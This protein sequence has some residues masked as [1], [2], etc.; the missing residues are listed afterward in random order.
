MRFFFKAPIFASMMYLAVIIVLAVAWCKL[1]AA[2]FL[3]L[4]I[5]GFVWG[6]AL[7]QLY[8]IFSHMWA[9]ALM[10]EY[11]MWCV[12]EMDAKIYNLPIVM[13]YA[14]YHHH[15][16][17]DDNWMHDTMSYHD[18]RGAIATAYAHWNSFSLLTSDYLISG[19]LMKI[20]LVYMLY[21]YPIYF[22]PFL[23]GHEIGVFLLP[24]SHDWV[25]ERKSGRFGFYYLFK[26][27][28]MLGI[29]ATK[30]DHIRHHDYDHAHVYQSFSSSGIYFPTLDKITDRM[31]NASFECAVEDKIPL[32]KI[33]WYPM[34]IVMAFF[35]LSYVGLL[36]NI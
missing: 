32:Y 10:L 28:E 16:T 26:P 22:T 14:F 35:Q 3:S 9:H 2:E 7:I 8:F 33:L 6:F 27:L 13:L 18:Y 15:H 21:S 25:H 1:P 29:F 23:L 31:W 24:I 5:F 19:W 36:T 4:Q 20:F 34:F 12:R 11:P 17:K 30:S